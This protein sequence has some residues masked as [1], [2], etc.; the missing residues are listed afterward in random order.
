ML[1]VESTAGLVNRVKI[2]GDLETD[3]ATPGFALLCPVAYD[4]FSG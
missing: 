3:I 2:L 4:Q 1:P